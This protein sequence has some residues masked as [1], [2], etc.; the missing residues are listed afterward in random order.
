MRLRTALAAS[1]AAPGAPMLTIGN[2]QTAIQ[3]PSLRKPLP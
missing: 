2:T 3:Q 1:R